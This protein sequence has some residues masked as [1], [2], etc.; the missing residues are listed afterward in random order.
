MQCTYHMHLQVCLQSC[1]WSNMLWQSLECTKWFLHWLLIQVRT[2]DPND[3]TLWTF[4]YS[5]IHS[6]ALWNFLLHLL[7]KPF[8][9]KKFEKR[10]VCV[11]LGCASGEAQPNFAFS[12]LFQIFSRITLSSN[13]MNSWSFFKSTEFQRIS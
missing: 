13:E 5:I 11:V 2:G 7:F 9:Q 1:F 4:L 12:E 8:R 10:Q 6:T 3:M